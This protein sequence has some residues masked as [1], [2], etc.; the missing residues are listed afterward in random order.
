MSINLYTF[1]IKYCT[2]KCL[3][4]LEFTIL[5]FLHISLKERPNEMITLSAL[6]VVVVVVVGLHV[7]V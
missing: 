5:Y 7:N 2:W 6:V 3:A 1:K 4:L